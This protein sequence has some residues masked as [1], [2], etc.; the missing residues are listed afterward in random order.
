MERRLFFFFHHSADAAPRLLFAVIAR[1]RRRK[2]KS[3][4]LFFGVAPEPGGPAAMSPP[5]GAVRC[6]KF[7]SHIAS[8]SKKLKQVLLRAFQ[9]HRV[10]LGESLSWG[11]EERPFFGE[12][13]VPKNGLAVVEVG[14]AT[15]VLGGSS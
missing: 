13:P 11:N 4:L 14:T 8:L 2:R 15:D 12:Q 5:D 9:R 1:D 3:S 6:R 7:P 10:T